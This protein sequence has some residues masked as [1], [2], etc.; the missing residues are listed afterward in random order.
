MPSTTVACAGGT[1][2]ISGTH[3]YHDL[4]ERE[5]A[6]LHAK[7]SA[8]VFTLGYVSN[9]ATLGTLGQKIPA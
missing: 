1:R 8:L 2:N 9:W 5:L 4:L 6:D 3:P 7:E